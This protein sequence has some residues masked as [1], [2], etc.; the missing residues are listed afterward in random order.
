LPEQWKTRMSSLQAIVGS[1]Q[2]KELDIKNSLRMVNADVLNKILKGSNGVDVPLPSLGARH[3]YLYYAL[4]ITKRASLDDIREKLIRNR[5]DSQSNELT[6]AKDLAV[7]GAES[8]DYPVF[9]RVSE[10]I[11]II[12][13]G[14][15]LSIEDVHYVGNTVKRVLDTIE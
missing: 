4:L 11:L 5:I 15:Y 3:I 6:T 12:P 1:E 7:F 9:N 10:S 2:L 8:K 14:I 13:N